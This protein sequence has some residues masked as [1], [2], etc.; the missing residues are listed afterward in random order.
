VDD[1][2][3]SIASPD[4]QRALFDLYNRVAE[5]G[6][7][8]IW[9]MHQSP[10][11]SSLDLADL[12]SRLFSGP[13][14]RVANLDDAHKVRLLRKRATLLGLDMSEELA[15]FILARLPRDLKSLLA[16]VD[17]LDAQSLSQQR[18]LTIPFV[19]G[20]LKTHDLNL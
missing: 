3:A 15:N 19:S 5:S 16:F 4:W 14:Y 13:V 1:I 8:F 9:S 20:I 7:A 12:Q 17:M 6:N 11:S 18:R 10:A 2:D